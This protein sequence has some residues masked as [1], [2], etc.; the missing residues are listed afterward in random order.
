MPVQ[1]SL[2][3]L[4][5]LLS[6][7]RV[8]QLSAGD[9]LLAVQEQHREQRPLLRARRRQLTVTVG[10]PKWTKQLELHSLGLSHALAR[11]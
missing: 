9:D 3:A 7:Q 8:D 6:P 2:C 5:R 4:G 1:R 11:R 10:D